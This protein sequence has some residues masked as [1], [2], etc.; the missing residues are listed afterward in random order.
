MPLNGT[1]WVICCCRVSRVSKVYNVFWNNCQIHTSYVSVYISYNIYYNIY[2]HIST[3]NMEVYI[4][5]VILYIYILEWIWFSRETSR[6]TSVGKTVKT[7]IGLL[8]KAWKIL[9]NACVVIPRLVDGL[10]SYFQFSPRI[11]VTVNVPTLEHI[12]EPVIEVDGAWWCL[13]Q[14]KNVVKNWAGYQNDINPI[15]LVTKH[16][17]ISHRFG[18]GSDIFLCGVRG[19]FVA[20][21]KGKIAFLPTTGV[22]WWGQF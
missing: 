2:I 5:N 11:M 18:T 10:D 3:Y 4:Y 14:K 22:S 8:R 1:S 15:P 21:L 13:Y 19:P 12:K 17:T 6:E 9:P 16:P 7:H 20:M